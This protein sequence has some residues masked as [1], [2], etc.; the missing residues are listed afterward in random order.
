VFEVAGKSGEPLVS[1]SI[2]GQWPECTQDSPG[3]LWRVAGAG[4]GCL[5]RIVCVKAAGQVSLGLTE[6]GGQRKHQFIPVSM[7]LFLKAG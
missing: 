6:G 3:S 7:T 4:V 5:R 1:T 2:R